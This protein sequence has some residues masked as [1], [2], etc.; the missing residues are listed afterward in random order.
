M[1]YVNIF[2]EI[3]SIMH[4]D[5]AGYE[6]K[7]GWDNPDFFAKKIERLESS[8]LMTPQLF[9]EIVNEYLISFQDRHMYFHLHHSEKVE[10]KTCGFFVRNYED[11]LYVTE[12]YEEN[13]FGKGARIVSI[14]GQS[15]SSIRKQQR[16][17]LRESHPE[18]EEWDEILNKAKYFELINE[19]EDAVK[20]ELN[21]YRRTPKKST[22]DIR[23]INEDTLLVTL[24][25]FGDTDRIVNLI[26]KHKDDLLTSKNVIVDVRHNSGGNA[27]AGNSLVRYFYKKGEK[28]SSELKVREFNCSDR[29]VEL[30]LEQAEHVRNSTDDED[31]L[32]MVEFAENQFKT[33]RNQGFVAFDFSEY[34]AD[35]VNDFEGED[36]PENVII[37][38][39][40]YCA[41]AGEEFV[42]TSKGSSKV[43]IVGRATMGL[44][45]YS[46]LV[47]IN[48]DNQYTLYYPISR[49]EQK[50]EVH[51]IHG[52]GIQPDI[53]IKW[54]P[55]HIEE[56]IDLQQAL[57]LINRS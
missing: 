16:A 33:S 34:I 55:K 17:M 41:S 22:Y 57:K 53:Y 4:Q 47:S 15:I 27:H 43:T 28:P 46:D 54:T 30:F 13:R 20:L 40:Y 49:L 37:L 32:K 39:D 21:L 8:E 50:T 29:N 24:S 10:V 18:R 36:N 42:G 5:Y 3:V 6:E 48:W 7:K 26:E 1:K 38:S 44:N 9:A 14:D 56:D 45:D 11:T 35:R 52:K 19:N 12:V 51:P 31:T 23:S 25:D 2:A